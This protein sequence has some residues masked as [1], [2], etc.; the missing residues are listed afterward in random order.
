M[1]VELE[2]I[3]AKVEKVLKLNDQIKEIAYTFKDTPNFFIP[4]PWIQFFR[5]R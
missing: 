1:L 2:N 4:R 5:W 3:P